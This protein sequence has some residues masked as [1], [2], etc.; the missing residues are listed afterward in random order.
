M[1]IQEIK[2]INFP[3]IIFSDSH[4]NLKNLKELKRSYPTNQFICLGDITY[5]F[6]KK[7]EIFNQY[8]IEYFIDN[9]IP[10]LTGNHESHI[11][12]CSTGD[13]FRPI[14]IFGQF[15][16]G[17]LSEDLDIYDLTQQHIDYLK[18][19]P[20]G[21]KLILP[22]NSNYLCFHNT[23]NDLWGYND[24]MDKNKFLNTYPIDKNTTEV[25]IGHH[26]KNFKV[27][28]LNVISKLRGIGALRDGFYALLT[29]NGIEIKK[30]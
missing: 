10:T 12:G 4:C 25:I 19:L 21:F 29:E 13:S 2:V 22:D 30:L 9:K 1:N 18:T 16:E 20:I 26:H 7:G 11:L 14:K 24:D 28:F 27:D 8:S 17:M 3:A 23:P 15:D 6:S 5:L